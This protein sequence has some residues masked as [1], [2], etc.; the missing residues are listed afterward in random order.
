MFSFTPDDLITFP[1][2]EAPKLIVFVDAEEEFRWHTFSSQAISVRNIA[3]QCRAQEI[4]NQFGVKPTYLVDYAV[5][6]QQEGIEPLK[7]ILDAGNCGIGAQLHPWVNPPIDEEITIHNTYPG[8]LPAALERAKIDRLTAAIIQ[9]FGV[10]PRV[11]KAGR[12]GAGPNTAA[13]LIEAGYWIDASVMPLTDFSKKGGP[14]Y[15]ES[16]AQ[17]Y[18][19]D[20][21]RRLLE[22]PNTVGLVGLM[23]RISRRG[24]STLLS[25]PSIACRIP[26]LLSRLGLF[27]RIRLTPE[28]ISLDE[29]KR[30]TLS[31]LQRDRR[32]FVLS[33]HS[34]SLL[35][36]GSPYVANEADLSAFLGWLDGYMRFF[37]GALGGQP[38]TA[39]DVLSYAQGRLREAA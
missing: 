32:L 1:R 21:D 29:A 33:Y 7:A 35:A 16:P 39:E 27:E 38:T 11:F 23:N 2:S 5:A 8:N 18:W 26:G 36:G 24:M 17:P 6:S 34:S 14:D 12:Y 13:A 22:I 10:R 37:F 25:N 31:L 4:L 20:R 19:I 15:T 30:M 28:G 9:N 3:A